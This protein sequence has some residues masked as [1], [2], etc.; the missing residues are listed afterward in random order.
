MRLVSLF[1]AF[2]LFGCVEPVESD[3]CVTAT[4]G[5]CEELRGCPLGTDTTDCDLVCGSSAAEEYPAVCAHDQSAWVLAGESEK[6]AGSGGSGGLSGTWDGTV[7]VRGARSDDLVDRHY[8]VFA[9]RRLQNQESVPVVFALG[10]FTVD[11]YWLAEFTEL[12]RMAD[13]EGFLVVYGQPE[14]RSFGGDWLFAWYV[15]QGAFQGGWSEN[16]DLA[17]LEAVLD[18]VSGAYNVDET[19]VFVTGHSR[20]AALSI[21]AA[22]ERP[23]VFQ[24]FC[25]QAGFSTVNEY[26]ERIVSL[27]QPVV[28]VLVHG[29]ADPD[30]S[31]SESDHLADVFDSVGGT[32]EILYLR[33]PGATHEWQSQHNQEVWDFLQSRMGS[34]K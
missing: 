3:G 22:T 9:P 11:L 19:K 10:G 1:L 26:D 29:D 5:T 34:S 32:E 17:Y 23:E 14:W 25:A 18:E 20:G 2:W 7:T 15:Y 6:E 8:R 21:I 4:N 27:G 16:P 13:R 28:G 31:V 33:V 30:V 12:N 24:G